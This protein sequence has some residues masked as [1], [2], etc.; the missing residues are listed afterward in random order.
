V[1]DNNNEDRRLVTRI[2][3]NVFLL[4]NPHKEAGALASRIFSSIW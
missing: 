4:G 1:P 2:L 3:N